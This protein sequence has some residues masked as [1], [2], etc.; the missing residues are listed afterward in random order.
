MNTNITVWDFFI[1]KIYISANSKLL[2]SV[3][4]LWLY[5]GESDRRSEGDKSEGSVRRETN[6]LSD[7]RN[8]LIVIGLRNVYVRAWLYTPLVEEFFGLMFRLSKVL[9]RASLKIILLF[10][11]SILLLWR[12]W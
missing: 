9:H 12:A 3:P 11:K 8:L 4:F 5:D 10:S 2:I 7:C 1:S 6:A